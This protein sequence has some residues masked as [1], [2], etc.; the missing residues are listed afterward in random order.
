M[1]HSIYTEAKVIP[2]LY[3]H[4]L[5]EVPMLHLTSFVLFPWIT[6]SSRHNPYPDYLLGFILYKIYPPVIDFKERTTHVCRMC[7]HISRWHL[8]SKWCV[9]SLSHALLIS[10]KYEFIQQMIL[11]SN[12]I[13]LAKNTESRMN[14]NTWRVSRWALENEHENHGEISS[15]CHHYHESQIGPKAGI[16]RLTIP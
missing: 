1:R 16:P 7:I 4:I 8:N 5:H 10:H 15:F 14:E 13:P 6:S 3:L 12:L 9:L 11:M 2:D